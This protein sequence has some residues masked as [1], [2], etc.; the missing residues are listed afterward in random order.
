MTAAGHIAADRTEGRYKLTGGEAG[1]SVYML[2][3]LGSWR[4]AKAA[5][6]P[7]RGG[8]E[9]SSKRGIDR[10]PCGCHLFAA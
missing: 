7:R 2:H 8:Q 6:L 1:E 5:N 10:F 9:R 3:D 4:W